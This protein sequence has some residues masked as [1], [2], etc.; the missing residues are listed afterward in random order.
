MESSLAFNAFDTTLVIPT[1]IKTMKV[2]NNILKNPNRI[3]RKRESYRLPTQSAMDMDFTSIPYFL[4]R[5]MKMI[6]AA[7]MA[8]GMTTP[9]AIKAL[10]PYRAIK[11]GFIIKVAA[12]VIEAANESAT[13]MDENDLFPTAYTSKLLVETLDLNT[14]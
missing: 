4:K 5:L 1:H 13:E 3:L 12:L 9:K 7:Y 11:P 2:I 10:K 8:N 6:S 14:K